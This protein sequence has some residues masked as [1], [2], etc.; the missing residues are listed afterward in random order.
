MQFQ[1][2]VIL[3]T[4]A[5]NEVIDYNIGS[6]DLFMNLKLMM[7][8]EIKKMLY[9]FLYFLASFSPSRNS[10]LCRVM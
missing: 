5:V 2:R 10:V 4:S 1:L 9:G 7:I 3:L 6:I 8:D